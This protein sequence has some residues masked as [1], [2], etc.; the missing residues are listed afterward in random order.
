MTD[1]RA[2]FRGLKGAIV[3]DL[4]NTYWGKNLGEIVQSR[5]E[6]GLSFID[7][8]ETRLTPRT[9]VVREEY[10]RSFE[11]IEQWFGRT[12]RREQKSPSVVLTGQPGIGECHSTRDL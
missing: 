11:A 5:G 6:V 7:L 3:V 8:T 12:D 2:V 10:E 1:L 4:Y 9:L